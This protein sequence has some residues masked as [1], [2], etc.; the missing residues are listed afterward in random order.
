MRRTG[1]GLARDMTPIDPTRKD[2]V[3]EFRRQPVGRQSGDL[4]RML[5]VMRCHP[6]LPHYILVCTEAQRTWRLA[7]KTPGRHTPV[8]LL[9]HPPF[10]DPLEAEWQVFRLRWKALFD[11]DLHHDR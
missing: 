7:T 5:N 8:E 10:H 3:D 1:T 4:R 11:E 2:L 6:D 9:D